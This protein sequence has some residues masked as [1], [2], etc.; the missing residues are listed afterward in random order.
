[1]NVLI[2]E[3]DPVTRRLLSVY[4]TKWG[5]DVMEAVDGA[6]AWSI[7]QKPEALSLVVSDWMLPG[8]NGLDLCRKVRSA[9]RAGYVYFIMLTA[10]GKQEDLLEG[11]E[12]G[13]DDYLVKP[14]NWNELKCRIKIGERIIRIENKI[15]ELAA[16]DH[17]TGVLNRRAFL[18]QLDK[19]FNRS[20]R[21]RSPLSLILMDIDHFK[22]VNDTFGHQAGDVVL[23]RF[24]D[25]LSASVRPYD[26]IGRYGGEE[27]IACLPGTDAFQA[28]SIAERFRETLEKL[29]IG[30]SNGPQCIR[31]TA[32]FGVACAS[33]GSDDSPDSLIRRA[34]EAMY[35][36]KKEGRNRVF[37]SG[38][39]ADSGFEDL[40]D[41][42][43]L[44][45]DDRTLR[46]GT[47][48]AGF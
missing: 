26:F 9:E 31:I 2:V 38:D 3:D 10:K 14:F 46:V 13:V 39:K 43:P 11:L 18:E 47:A 20:L 6:E 33:P 35:E 44:A 1:V 30:I 24:T 32:S 40:K 25:Q 15:L 48:S 23:Q 34:D 42:E 21:Q 29:N 19:D 27:F 45:L 7:L 17:L 22:K 8:M 36:A 12:N 16:T 4:I 5:Y 28:K 41:G 37:V